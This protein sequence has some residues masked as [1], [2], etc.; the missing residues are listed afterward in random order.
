MAACGGETRMHS[1]NLTFDQFKALIEGEGG[2]D[3]HSRVKE[4]AVALAAHAPQTA[5]ARPLPN[6]MYFDGGSPEAT[7]HGSDA[8]AAA[9]AQPSAASALPPPQQQQQ[10]QQQQAVRFE[11]AGGDSDGESDDDNFKPAL[12]TKRNGSLSPEMS[13]EMSKH[14]S[15]TLRMRPAAHLY[16]GGE[17]AVPTMLPQRPRRTSDAAEGSSPPALMPFKSCPASK[18]QATPH[19]HAVRCRRIAALPACLTS[20]AGTI[21]PRMFTPSLQL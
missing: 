8:G 12:L 20:R 13:K 9:A 7:Q 10:Q 16:N 3:L 11:G 19:Q 15:E 17:P 5:Q 2:F 14:L 18:T 21:A 1:C 4:S 6:G